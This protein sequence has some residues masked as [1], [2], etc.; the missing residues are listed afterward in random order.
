MRKRY[1]KKTTSVCGICK[2]HK[3]G[4]AIRWKVKDFFRLKQDEA[5]IKEYDIY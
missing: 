5:E 1:K 2:P 3:R 4:H